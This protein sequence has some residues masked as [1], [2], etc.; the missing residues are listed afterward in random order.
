LQP[1]W[2]ALRNFVQTEGAIANIVQRFE[3]A[4]ISIEGLADTIDD[5]E[6]QELLRKRMHLLQRSMSMV[7]AA[8]IDKDAGEEYTRKFASVNGLDTIW[9]R[10]AHSVAKAAKMPMTQLFGMS[11]SGLAT[12]DKSGRANWRKQVRAY[13]ND[14][15]RPALKRYYRLLT[16]EPV[17]VK[18]SPLDEATAAEEAQIAKTRAEARALAYDRGVIRDKEWRRKLVEEGIIENAEFNPD[19]GQPK[20]DVYE[21]PDDPAIP[22]HVPAADRPK[23]VEAWNEAYDETNSEERAFRAANSAIQ[24]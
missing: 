19:A 10:L 17:R 1:V 11:P 4:T 7:N 13:Q 15:V 21:G 5:E 22:D 20:T 12:D 24:D 8:L 23:W 2:E 9:D 16:G 14:Y 18:F 6:G 3:T